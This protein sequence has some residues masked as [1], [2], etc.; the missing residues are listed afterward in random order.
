[1]IYQVYCSWMG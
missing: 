1:V